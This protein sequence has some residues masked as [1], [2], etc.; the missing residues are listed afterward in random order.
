[1][2]VAHHGQDK[3]S[4]SPGSAVALTPH[5]CKCTHQEGEEEADILTP[6]VISE[7]VYATCRALGA[8]GSFHKEVM[9][10]GARAHTDTES[11]SRMPYSFTLCFT[12]R[13]LRE[14]I[15]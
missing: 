7:D 14:L 6:S 3:V 11:H 13:S 5:S 8:E 9:A 2:D 12:H 4:C 15:V 10:Q 1:M